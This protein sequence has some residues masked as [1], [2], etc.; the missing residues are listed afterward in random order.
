MGVPF[1]SS[2]ELPTDWEKASQPA[3]IDFDRKAPGIN[4]GAFLS[5]HLH[6]V[7]LVM[8]IMVTSG[9]CAVAGCRSHCYG[10]AQVNALHSCL[11]LFQDSN[12][13]SSVNRLGFMSSLLEEFLNQINK[14]A[15]A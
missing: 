12:D 8:K 2:R 14:F 6:A 13:R 7:T 4:S 1:A 11:V 15:M 3:P 9:Y 10:K 5:D